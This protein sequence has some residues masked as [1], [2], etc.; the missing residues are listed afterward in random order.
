MNSAVLSPPRPALAR[1]AEACEAL[2]EKSLVDRHGL[3]RS[4]VDIDTLRPFPEGYFDGKCVHDYPGHSWR[5]F[6]EYMSYENVGMCSGAYLAALVWKYKATKDFGVLKKA[7]RAFR[8]IKW[9]YDISR[10]IEDGFYCK[11]YGGKVSEQVSSDQYIYTFAGLD[12]FMEVADTETAKQCRDMCETM[13]R[14]WIRKNYSYPYFGEDLNW[15]LERFPAFLWLAWKYTEKQEFLDE[16]DRLCRLDEVRNRIPFGKS[17]EET[18]IDLKRRDPHFDFEKNSSLRFFNIMAENSESGFL[19]LEPLL[20]YGAPD[21]N[22]WLRKIRIMFER[23]R[24]MLIEHG[25]AKIKMLYDTKT[26]KITSVEKVMN[27]SEK[28][29]PWISQVYSFVGKVNSA[30]QSIMF[31]RAALGMYEYLKEPEMLQISAKILKD[32][33]LCKLNWRSCEQFPDELQWINKVF[34]G[35]AAVHW[36]WA[37]WEGAAKYGDGWITKFAVTKNK[38]STDFQYP[39]VNS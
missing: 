10:N 6:S 27:N 2:I 24:N 5:D 23:D 7:Y 37:Y 29:A 34:S 31:A 25:S 26:G 30:M 35:D 17:L 9:L 13:V 19:S 8:G 18:V 16:F 20:K 21:R 4:A 32:V 28:S 1:K 38:N 12:Q 22:L 3:V 15:P 11:C 39:F 36:L 33:N 14:W